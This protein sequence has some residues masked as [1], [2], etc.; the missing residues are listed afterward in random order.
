MD[1]NYKPE[2][3]ERK[4]VFGITFEQR[5]NDFTIDAEL[6]K[7]IVT[8]NKNMTEEA[9]RD[10]I[11]ALITLEIYPVQFGMLCRKRAD[12]RCGSRAA[13]PHSLH[14]TGRRE[15]GQMASASACDAY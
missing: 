3:T 13:I 8:K 12:H 5:R 11:I 4:Q 9:K 15:G 1:G 7:D 14:Q 10:L 2:L 6:L